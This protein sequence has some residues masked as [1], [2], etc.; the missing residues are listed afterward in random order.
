MRGSNYGYCHDEDEHERN[1]RR[2]A[3]YG[4][5]DHDYYDRYT[6]DPCKDIYTREYEREERRI[7]TRREEEQQE[8][9]AEERRHQRRQ[10]EET[11]AEFYYSQFEEPS[12]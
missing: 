9:E 4:R 10:A 3:Q 1:A 5:P 2:D 7:E 12:Q 11:D 6:S 8:M